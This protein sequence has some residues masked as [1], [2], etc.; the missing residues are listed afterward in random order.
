MAAKRILL[1]EDEPG[2]REALTSLLAEEGYVVCAA[3]TGARGLAELHN[4]HPDT[5]VCDFRLP[6][7]D[8]LQILR[9]VRRT[10]AWDVCFIVVTAGCGGEEAEHRLQ[11]EA[12]FFFRK[13]I[14][15][16]GLCSALARATDAEGG[17]LAVGS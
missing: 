11:R 3:A 4:F 16:P 12:D 9:H 14:D 6:D 2:A 17:C 5:V 15:L 10:A 7:T 13:P 1:I 8:G